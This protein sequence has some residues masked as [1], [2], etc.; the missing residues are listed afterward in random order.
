MSR[1]VAPSRIVPRVFSEDGGGYSRPA[2]CAHCGERITKATL[3]WG[4]LVSD[5][6][7]ITRPVHLACM[8]EYEMYCRAIDWCRGEVTPTL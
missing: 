2:R 4:R 7:P 5:P 8:R 6:E 3:A 1:R